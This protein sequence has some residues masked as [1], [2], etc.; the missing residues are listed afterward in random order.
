VR[1]GRE[2]GDVTSLDQQPG[3]AGRS[4][5]MQAGQRGPG[6]RKQRGKFLVGGLGALVDALQVADQLSC[7]LPARPACRITW[8]D[9]GEQC[10]GLGRGQA[11]LGAAGDEFQQQLVQL[12]DHPDV[13]LAQGPAPVSQDPQHHELLISHHWP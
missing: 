4:D 3:S 8:A 11:F 1:P 13:V 6:G 12:A 10:F 9:L 5:P 7:C 2:P